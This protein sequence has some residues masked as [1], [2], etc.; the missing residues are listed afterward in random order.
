VLVLA[1][2]IAIYLPT[3]HLLPFARAISDSYLYVPLSCLALL[4]ALHCERWLTL[5]QRRAQRWLVLV[6]AALGL[7]LAAGSHA[8]LPRW[9][10]GLA[11]W[12]PVVRRHPRLAPAH[13]LLGDEL[14]FRG[15]PG[16]AVG[17][18]RR[19]FELEYD[20]R[21]LVEFGTV[22]GLA[23]RLQDAECVLIEAVAYGRRGPQA[24]YNY[25]ALLAYHPEYESRHPAISR[26]LLTQL[27]S[28]RRTAGLVWPEPLEPGFQRQ[29]A[30]VRHAVTAPTP[31]PQ[32]NCAVLKPR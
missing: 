31:W 6:L 17:P 21:F 25:A 26:R 22:L 19:A 12:Q 15:Q 20:P 2:A 27:V 28:L 7:A 4:G 9:R 23:G 1:L 29:L 32:R 10:G 18:Y 30:R 8:Q 5:R 16:L 13:R 24:V 3:S 11:L 14:M